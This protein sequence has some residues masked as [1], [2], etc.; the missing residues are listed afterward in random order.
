MTGPYRFPPK[1]GPISR[2]LSALV[3]AIIFTVAFFV[4][5]VFLAAA[6]GAIAVLVLVF[7]LRFG[8]LRRKWGRQRPEGRR[9][10]GVTLEGE[11]SVTRTGKPKGEDRD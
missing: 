2:F 1:Q 3:L 6:L 8:W 10:G 5:T 4:G 9:K 7:Y 11:Y